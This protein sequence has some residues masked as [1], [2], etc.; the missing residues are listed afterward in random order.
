MAN[1][2]RTL[3][4]T[5]FAGGGTSPVPLADAVGVRKLEVGAKRTFERDRLPRCIVVPVAGTYESAPQAAP[6]VQQTLKATWVGWDVHLW[7]SDLDA[8]REMERAFVEW[9]EGNWPS[10][11]RLQGSLCPP[12]MQVQDGEAIVVRVQMK[13]LLLA[14]PRKRVT[15]ATVGF[16]ASGAASGDKK[17]TAGET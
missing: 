11:H 2:P 8:A 6:G 1:P 10:A 7:A 17:L 9:L 5:L 14:T 16:D 3:V 13:E 4:A 12:N 15:V